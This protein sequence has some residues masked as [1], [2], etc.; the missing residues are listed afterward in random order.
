MESQTRENSSQVIK[1][2]EDQGNLGEYQQFSHQAYSP[3]PYDRRGEDL[4]FSNH[5][6]SPV[7]RNSRPEVEFTAAGRPRHLPKVQSRGSYSIFSE[8]R[9]RAQ[10][11]V[12]IFSQKFQ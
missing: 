1:Q 7:R 8:K 5:V 10:P 6:Y 12:G 3:I 9:G 4:Q 2:K 11:R